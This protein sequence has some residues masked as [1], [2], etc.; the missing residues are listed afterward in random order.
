M[1]EKIQKKEQMSINDD[2]KIKNASFENSLIKKVKIK[3]EFE[4]RQKKTTKTNHKSLTL[5]TLRKGWM[6]IMRKKDLKF[7]QKEKKDNYGEI[8]CY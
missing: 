7:T 4:N 6:N 8:L 1:R 3:N 2:E 5:S